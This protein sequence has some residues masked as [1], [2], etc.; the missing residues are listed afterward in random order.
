MLGVKL[1]C[2]DVLLLI[3][4]VPAPFT[5]EVVQVKGDAVVPLTDDFKSNGFVPH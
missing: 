3:A 4:N 2:T 1:G 5:N